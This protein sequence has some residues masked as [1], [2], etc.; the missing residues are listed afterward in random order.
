M[1]RRGWRSA[2]LNRLT[3]LSGRFQVG[4][5]GSQTVAPTYLDSCLNPPSIRGFRQAGRSSGDMGNASRDERVAIMW[6]GSFTDQPACV[7]GD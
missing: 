1:L 7:G 5:A 2:F 3:Y 6:R 4:Q